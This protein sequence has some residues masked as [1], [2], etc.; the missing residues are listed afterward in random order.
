MVRLLFA[1]L[2][3]FVMLAPGSYGQSKRIDLQSESA[4]A[5]TVRQLL[6]ES[7]RAKAE[8]EAV[9]RARGLSV[10]GRTLDGR[11]YELMEF[12]PDA[13]SV[14]YISDNR[15]AAIT[16]NAHAIRNTAPYNLS[17]A[18]LRVG[19]WDEAGARPTHQ[20]LAG[21]VT[22]K[23]GTPVASHSTH[24]AGTIGAAGIDPNALGMAPSVLFDSYD[25]A[26]DYPEMTAAAA[27][28]PGQAGRIHLSNH[29]YGTL[30]G[31]EQGDFSGNTGYHWFGGALAREDFEFGRYSARARDWD[32]LCVAAPYYLPFKST[33][34]D[35]DHAA[36][37]NGTIYWYELNDSFGNWV[38]K[39]YNPATD[40][41]PDGYKGGYDTIPSYANA[42]NIVTVGAVN[43]AVVGGNRNLSGATMSSFSGWG[44]S[45]DG[46]IK[47]DLVAN[48][49]SVYSALATSDTAYG[50]ASGSSMSTP[51]A[52]GTALLL[53][54]Y[55]NRLFPGS[56]MRNSTLKG[57]LIHTADD[58]GNP[59]PDYQFGWGLINAQAAADLIAAHA[60][61]P[62][63]QRIFE[64]QLDGANPTRSYA[65]YWNGVSPIRVTLCWTDP[66]ANSSVT[67][68]DPTP[69]LIND[70]DLR[71]LGPGGSPTYPPFILDPDNP[72]NPAITGDNVRDNVE[73]M[74][75]PAPPAAG[76]YTVQV[77]HKGALN[78]GS[79]V[80]SLLTTGLVAAV[81][82]PTPTPTPTHTG[83]PTPTPTLAPPSAPPQW[84]PPELV[85]LPA[86]SGLHAA[87]LDLSNYVQDDNTPPHFLIFS[88]VS[89]TQPGV[90]FVSVTPTGV[91]SADVQPNQRG[92]NTVVFRVRDA[93]GN[94]ADVALDFAV[95]GA[96]GVPL[97]AWQRLE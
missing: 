31:W 13:G 94:T 3:G 44:P 14:Y 60:A 23:D 93:S 36:P 10:R 27:T 92:V 77:S 59:G 58:L 65:L 22:L 79:Q 19:I 9:A 61:T 81:G 11:T 8:A 16:T 34:N 37:P 74:F 26:S 73:Q 32:A 46:R 42:K 6:D 75:L 56:A 53:V 21:R 29:S 89:Q 12:H 63:D 82:T 96:T 28:A 57:L 39:T 15:N 97:G 45:D 43:D 7:V 25:W 86:N 17:G 5:E 76:Q 85:G 72:G 71:V 69:R 88:V 80:F 38:S 33:G 50:A 84:F 24:V 20:E 64:A 40:P 68:N 67:L 62:A 51:N 83:T 30:A 4:R 47:P 1:A 2:L 52:A 48:G 95:M 70:L 54:E 90:V 18:G 41:Y 78:G 87:A 66:E 49:V 35:R 55:Y 91:V